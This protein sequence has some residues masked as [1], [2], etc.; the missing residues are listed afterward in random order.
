MFQDSNKRIKVAVKE[1]VASMQHQHQF[2]VVV[3][4]QSAP[5]SRAISLG[6]VFDKLRGDM[7]KREKHKLHPFFCVTPS[8]Y[9]RLSLKAKMK[10]NGKICLTRL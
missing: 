5:S 1:W 9:A 10:S 4:S 6:R 3:V 8:G 7:P 2:L